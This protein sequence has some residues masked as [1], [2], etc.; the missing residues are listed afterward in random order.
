MY[1]RLFCLFCLCCCLPLA[2]QGDRPNLLLI[3]ADDLG[4]DHLNGYHR[5]ARMAITPTLD[6][7]RR[8][9]ITFTNAFSAPVCSPSRAAMMTGKYGLNNGVPGVPGNLDLDQESIFKALATHTDGAYADAVVGKW[10]LSLPE[11]PDH[12]TSHGADYYLGLLGGFPES[13]FAWERTEN[14]TTS[15]STEYVTTALTDAAINWVGAQTDPWFLWLAHPAPHAPFHVPPTGLYTTTN[16]DGVVGQ[17]LAMVESVDHEINRLLNSMTPEVRA[18]TLLIFVGD[19]G[20]PVRALQDYPEDRGKGTLY[21]GG[22][23]VPFIVA[24]AGVSRQGVREAALVHLTDIYATLLEVA[25]A[26]LPGGIYNSQSFAHLLTAA[27]TEP[28]RTYNYTEVASGPN[29]G[30]TIRNEQYKLINWEDGTQAFYAVATD[31]FELTNL[32]EAPL[33]TELEN[34]KADLEAEAAAIRNGWSCRDDIQNGEETGID[35]GTDDCGACTTSNSGPEGNSAV[36]V[37]PNPVTEA[38]T[39]LA[40]GERI[41]YVRLFDAAGRLLLEQAGGQAG[42]VSVQVGRLKA[43]LLIV[44]VVTNNGT[45]S[46]KIVKW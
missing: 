34:I 4:A 20:T 1:T 29:P 15:L 35:C 30:W 26:E 8:V 5:G 46:R 36:T 31:S 41:E 9:G 44:E 17:Y 19:N 33:S 11:N 16:T 42:R 40:E 10:H 32:L 43:W 24:G 37:F 3:I 22:V 45:S 14:G 13:Y 38:L 18:N 25:G 23:R 21:Q 39:V 6:S 27:G 12:P 28:T 2:A 7:L